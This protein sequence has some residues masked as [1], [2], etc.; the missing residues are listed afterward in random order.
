MLNLESETWMQAPTPP[1]RAYSASGV[2]RPLRDEHRSAQIRAGDGQLVMEVGEYP[3]VSLDSSVSSGDGDGKLRSTLYRLVDGEWTILPPVPQVRRSPEGLRLNGGAVGALEEISVGPGGALLATARSVDGEFC[4]LRFEEGAWRLGRNFP[5]AWQPDPA[6]PEVPVAPVP[7]LDH[8]SE[9]WLFS[10]EHQ[11]LMR[12]AE[13][14]QDWT[15]TALP[16]G[17]NE[18]LE[19]GAD[20]DELLSDFHTTATY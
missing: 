13:D 14:S 20:A 12:A 10:S 11:Q 7:F 17:F 5:S 2:L 4:V 15:A 8:N 1:Q 16:S 19:L 3:K 18:E 9:A 6:D